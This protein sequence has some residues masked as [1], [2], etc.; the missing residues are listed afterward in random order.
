[1]K[2]KDRLAHGDHPKKSQ[3]G[4]H[5][6][7][8][9][10]SGQDV[11]HRTRK[12]SHHRPS[13]DGGHHKGYHHGDKGSPMTSSHPIRPRAGTLVHRDTAHSI[14]SGKNAE[15]RSV[16]TSD[17]VQA[18]LGVKLENTFKLQPDFT[19]YET[20]VKK[21]ITDVI[22]SE[23]TLKN[24]DPEA[25]SRFCVLASDMIK[26]KVKHQLSLPRYKIVSSVMVGERGDRDT[27]MLISSRCLWDQ[28]FDNHVTVTVKKSGFYVVGMV[29]AVYA[30]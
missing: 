27:S 9:S 22:K 17:E 1:M 14:V 3:D 25:M 20:P 18:S 10:K 7:D 6:D 26:E 30:E 13:H 4:H 11:P 19:F 28:R 29:F 2:D 12:D 15:K 23:M 16:G 21:I 24:Y 5:K 8:H